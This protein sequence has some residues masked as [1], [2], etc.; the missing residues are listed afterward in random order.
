MRM[1]W[2]LI[3]G[4]FFLSSSLSSVL[5]QS[6]SVIF[7]ESFDL[8]PSGWSVVQQDA[9]AD[10]N[11]AST[12]D[13]YSTAQAVFHKNGRATYDSWLVSP[14][15]Y[16]TL[17]NVYLKFYEKNYYMDW[18]SYSGVYI[19]K[20]SGQAGHSDFFEIYESDQISN[21]YTERIIDLSS[22]Y[23]SG[24]E[25]YIAFVYQ[26]SSAHS[27]AHY[28]WVD[29]VEICRLTS[30]DLGV[31]DVS[32]SGFINQ[33]DSEILL[34]SKIKNYSTSTIYDR[35]VTLKANG[36]DIA[37]DYISEISPGQEEIV[38]SY[39]YSQLNDAGFYNISSEVPND[40][41][42]TNNISET[43]MWI[44]KPDQLAEDF[45]GNFLPPRWSQTSNKM[46]WSKTSVP[47]NQINGTASIIVHQ[48]SID[49]EEMLIT[50]PLII[51]GSVNT[52]T[53][54]T[55]GIANTW[56]Y[57]SS[58]L[59]VKY[60]EISDSEW[61]NL[62]NSEDYAVTG[63]KVRLVE[64][65]IS[66]LVNGIYEFA[67]VTSSTFDHPDPLDFTRSRIIIDD[68]VGPDKVIFPDMPDSLCIVS[69]TAEGI[70][71]SWDSV[72]SANL[73]RIYRSTEP[74]SGFAEIGTSATE[75]YT[76]SNVSS[77]NKYF[78]YITADNA[79]K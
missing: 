69:V 24:E 62:G 64:L 16:L 36:I 12:K 21:D 53:Y 1:F 18:Y 13:S 65:D 40:A 5:G 73:Y 79:K 48:L 20:G 33:I 11:W 43:Q 2:Y 32:T 58:S 27:N 28:W 56:G 45:N 49:P 9:A 6:K 72:S 7:S 44:V 66:H 63:D 39:W 77:G 8:F 61:S 78:Y 19:S 25:I 75:T 70:N 68:V 74:Y 76:D 34:Y 22:Y 52:L 54:W 67:F 71:L 23:Y 37:H 59:Q 38:T 30:F 31:K 17:D 4:T 47:E 29:E 35:Q 42:N 14:P 3:L 15:I 57:G 60:K 46:N 26:D 51:D 10:T 55:K 41:N 50:C